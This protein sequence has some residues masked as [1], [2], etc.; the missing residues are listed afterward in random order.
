MKRAAL[1]LFVAGFG[2]LPLWV[3]IAYVSYG[4]RGVPATSDYWGTAPWLIVGG[5]AG[6]AFTLAIAG[7]TIAIHR[8][9]AGDE[10]RKRRF[11]L[12]TFGLL[13]C[14]AAAWYSYRFTNYGVQNEP[15]QAVEFVRGDP[16][17][18]EMVGGQLRADLEWKERIA[19]RTFYGVAVHGTTTVYAF[20]TVERR[21]LGGPKFAI[22]CVKRESA[23]RSDSDPCAQ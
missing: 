12:S 6:S 15:L 23:P 20:V 8:R 17:V 2:L 19:S 14:A 22:A 7:A 18:R 13:V 9:T 11:S 16:T 21:W 4:G 10:A 3:A 5:M 1:V